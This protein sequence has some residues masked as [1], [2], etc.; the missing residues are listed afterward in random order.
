MCVPE[1]LVCF[2]TLCVLLGWII[3]GQHSKFS[4]TAVFF[5]TG[6]PTTT[7]HKTNSPLLSLLWFLCEADLGR[8]TFEE[9]ETDKAWL[10]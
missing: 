3:I 4:T 9:C 6:N 2:N 10:T 1:T 5:Q 8:S 7:D